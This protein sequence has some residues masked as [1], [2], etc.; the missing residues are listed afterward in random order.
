MIGHYLM[1]NRDCSD[2]LE[3]YAKAFNVQVADKQT[4][5]DLPPN[6]AFPIPE[7][8]KHLVLHSLLIVEGIE[9]MCADSVVHCDYG[10]NMF[11]SITLKDLETLQKTWDILKEGG[12][13][14]MELAPQ[15]FAAAHGSL[16]DKFG[17]NWMLTASE[18]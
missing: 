11:V 18:G 17:I 15:Y 1:F 16:R 7:E 3:L 13:V 5:G 8:D 10:D 14:Y 4:Y 2:A 6:P 12:E 9:L